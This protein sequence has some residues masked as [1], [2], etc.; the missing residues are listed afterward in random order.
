MQEYIGELALEVE[1]PVR[2]PMD[3]PGK[4]E[5]RSPRVVLVTAL[6]QV[7]TQQVQQ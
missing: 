5:D 2:D 4:N 7:C 1:V 3:F 6:T